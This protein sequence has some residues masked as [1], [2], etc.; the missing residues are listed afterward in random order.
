MHFAMLLAVA[1]ALNA[2]AMQGS[3]N[4]GFVD[5][6]NVE[7]RDD[8]CF[9]QASYTPSAAWEQGFT[10]FVDTQGQMSLVFYDSQWQFDPGDSSDL[11]IA[12][13]RSDGTPSWEQLIGTVI[14]DG[15]DG[16]SIILNFDQEASTGLRADLYEGDTIGLFIG[17]ENVIGLEIGNNAKAFAM[18]AECVA[19][20]G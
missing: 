13:E 15:G 14:E 2:V 11:A 7:Q 20:V 6:W 16:R 18:L 8:G 9:M 10:V 5:G 17:T 1:G 12:I 3:T 19:K 4:L